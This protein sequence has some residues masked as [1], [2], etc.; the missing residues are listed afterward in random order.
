M[1]HFFDNQEKNTYANRIFSELYLEKGYGETS[2]SIEA[3]K[4][5]D[6]HFKNN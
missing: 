3:M 1:I 5:T 2:A 6:N 4:R